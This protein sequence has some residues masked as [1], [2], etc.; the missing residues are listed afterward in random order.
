MQ[1]GITLQGR[2]PYGIKIS[3]CL[4]NE[5][6]EGIRFDGESQLRL[7]TVTNNTF[8]KTRHGILFSQPPHEHSTELVFRR[9]LFI[10]VGEAEV[11]VEPKFDEPRFRAMLSPNPP[12]IQNNWSDRIKPATPKTAE[13]T[14]LFENGGRQGEQNLLLVSTDPSNPKFLAPTGKSP[15]QDVAG[16]Q[17]TEYKWIGAVGP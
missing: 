2:S 9:N 15:H 8:Q 13:L 4:F 12:G 1:A 14:I 10:G 3:G 6:T 11:A 7:I 17:P 5:L 16:A